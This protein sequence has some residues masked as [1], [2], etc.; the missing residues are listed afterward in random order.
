MKYK[1]FLHYEFIY[2]NDT[3]HLLF[4]TPAHPSEV[5]AK[6]LRI[7]FGTVDK[8]LCRAIP[9]GLKFETRLT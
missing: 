6:K 9:L 1:V 2:N 3:I 5:V 4:N 7:L 8:K